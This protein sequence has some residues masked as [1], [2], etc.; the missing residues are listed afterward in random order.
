MVEEFYPVETDAANSNRQAK[1]Q[2]DITPYQVGNI[3]RS[4]RESVTAVS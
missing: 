3:E 1:S 2:N 4:L